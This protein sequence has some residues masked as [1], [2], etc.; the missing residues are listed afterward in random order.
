MKTN[1]LKTVWS[2]LF[3]K[4]SVI[5][6]GIQTESNELFIQNTFIPRAE[7]EAPVIMEAEFEVFQSDEAG[8]WG[9]VLSYCQI[10]GCYVE[11]KEFD[12]EEEA[13]EFALRLTREAKE[14]N[15]KSVCTE[16][17]KEYMDL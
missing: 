3:G 16:C 13:N 2:S 12:T 1:K 5:N 6:S 11:T 15:Y 9:V 14:P 8:S 4:N 10:G 17:Y 7:A